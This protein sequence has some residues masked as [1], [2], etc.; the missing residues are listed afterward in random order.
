MCDPCLEHVDNNFPPLPKDYIQEFLPLRDELVEMFEKTHETI[1]SGDLSAIPT[2]L[3]EGNAMK[4][5]LSQI[6]HTAQDRVNTTHGNI[7]LDLLYLNT[8]QETQ[9]LVSDL[10]HLLRG[11]HRFNQ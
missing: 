6:R 11:I 3:A 9:E 8:L 7:R 1:V 2:L 4:S 5:K 10:R